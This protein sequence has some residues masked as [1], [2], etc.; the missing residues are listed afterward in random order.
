MKTARPRPLVDPNSDQ[1]PGGVGRIV[2]RDATW[3]VLGLLLIAAL[4]LGG[5]HPWTR[6]L[7]ALGALAAL[8]WAWLRYA[9]LGLRMPLEPMGG[10]LLLASSWT[11]L[12]W[13]PMPAGIVKALAPDTMLAAVEAA[14]AVGGAIP[15][16][17]P[18]SLSPTNSALGLLTLTGYAA[19]FVVAAD[20]ARRRRARTLILAVE[21]VALVTLAA[22]LAH[23]AMG[24]THV[25]GMDA[26][27]VASPFV[28]SFLNP[29][30]AGALMMLASIVALGRWLKA[31]AR[32]HLG[33]ASLLAAGVAATGSR[34]NLGVMIA[35]WAFLLL[36]AWRRRAFRA[37]PWLPL[38]ITVAGFAV[39]VLA[40]FP[41]VWSDAATGTGV[42]RAEIVGHWQVGAAVA[43]EHPWLGTGMGAFGTVASTQMG[44]F[45]AGLLD[46]AHSWPLQ[47]VADWG[48]PAALAITLLFAWGLFTR[49]RAVWT[50]LSLLGLAVALVA[51]VVQNLVDFSAY[52]PGVGFAA[53]VVAGTLAGAPTAA[54]ETAHA[55]LGAGAT[56]RWPRMS[57]ASVE[58]GALLLVTVLAATHV[59][60]HGR[61]AYGA[62][63]E[64]ALATNAPDTF[65]TTSMVQHHPND[66]YAFWLSGRMALAAG[67]APRAQ[68]LLARS[69]SLAPNHGGVHLDMARVA[70]TQKASV[71]AVDH[72]IAAAATGHKP[73]RTA[74][75]LVAKWP[76]ASGAVAQFLASGPKNALAVV[77]HQT[78]SGQ[79]ERAE[80]TIQRALS[81]HRGSLPVWVVALDLSV[82]SRDKARL[83]RLADRLAGEAARAEGHRR[84][85][86]VTVD[87]TLAQRALLAGD[88]IAAKAAVTRAEANAV[89]SDKGRLELARAEIAAVEQ[90][91]ALM[92]SMDL[93]AVGGTPHQ[94][95][96]RL[97]LLSLG[98]EQRKEIQPAIAYLQ[99]AL[100]ILPK[101]PRTTSVLKRLRSKSYAP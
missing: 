100:V 21:A 52:I 68:R 40:V 5:V 19:V 42:W 30:H 76:V 48:L 37:R 61:D 16:W 8:A 60:H 53:A 4:A 31:E 69:V 27:A 6:S 79:P 96:R 3:W 72:L 70:V 22:A 83:G 1:P 73:R 36:L 90:N 62:A 94:R 28:S 44:S 45:E 88:T 54:S 9:W 18:L 38:V 77:R 75:R 63:A 56:G 23:V 13:V 35:A 2:A 10:A 29:K 47:M 95:V 66:Y 65:D 49:V 39:L 34:A 20:L 7:L 59:L 12:Q 11:F 55:G 15:E 67:A 80:A 86:L 17:L 58:V 71:T 85:W 43:S 57:L 26:Y 98:A 14:N 82:A 33:I 64:T 91:W 46:H 74:A 99:R 78:L 92:Q 84:P 101:D 41:G 93:P 50:N 89:A 87:W 51:L 32:F 97:Q 81:F 25:Y 24:A